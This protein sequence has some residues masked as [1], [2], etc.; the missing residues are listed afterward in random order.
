MMSVGT[1][2]ARKMESPL[3]S[4]S[5]LGSGFAMTGVM[6]AATGAYATV[7]KRVLL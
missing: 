5:A 6:T 1:T 4:E 7:T 3:H 2:L